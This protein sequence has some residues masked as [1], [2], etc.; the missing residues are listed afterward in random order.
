VSHIHTLDTPGIGPPILDLKLTPDL[1]NTFALAAKAG[2]AYQSTVMILG[3]TGVGKTEIARHIHLTSVRANNPFV[4]IDLSQATASLFEDELFGHE[5]GA[6]TGA[7]RGRVSRLAKADGGTVFLDE[8][9]TLP[10]DLQARL[11]RLVQ[12][13]TFSPLGS[14][15]EIR[16][17]VRFL[18]ATSCDLGDKVLKGEFR[19]DL[20]HRLNVLQIT[21]PPLRERKGDIIPLAEYFLQQ[22]SM[23]DKISQKALSEEAKL[24]LIEHTWPGNVRGLQNEMC[25]ATMIADGDIINASDLSFFHRKQGMVDQT[26]SS[27]ISLEP[28]IDEISKLKVFSR[29]EEWQANLIRFII[30]QALEENDFSREKASRFLGVNS[31]TL[32]SRI[33][34]Y[35]NV[36]KIERSEVNTAVAAWNETKIN[37]PQLRFLEELAA[38]VI[39][40]RDRTTNIIGEVDN[41]FYQA[42]IASIRESLIE[43]NFVQAHVAKALGVHSTTISKFIQENPSLRDWL[44]SERLASSASLRLEKR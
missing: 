34:T 20:Y 37:L 23:T 29:I 19:E 43:N 28:F 13:R 15:K 7:K 9:G 25:R 38:A 17:D 21:V 27:E 41:I 24:A 2:R 12:E 4:K 3:E 8:I 16:I 5:D 11:L 14:D 33:M 22:A 40:R 26:P 30:A 44:H 31:N 10:F 42:K 36:D 35:M 39:A 32:N 18:V 1:A 6:Y